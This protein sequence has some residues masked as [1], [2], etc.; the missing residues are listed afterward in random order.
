LS[1]NGLRYNFNSVFPFFQSLKDL[2]FLVT[3]KKRGKKAGSLAGFGLS[4]GFERPDNV[5]AC[6]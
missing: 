5:P 1:V 3:A 4:C 6:V 2:V